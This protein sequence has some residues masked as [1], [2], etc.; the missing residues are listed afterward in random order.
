MNAQNDE[1]RMAN[2]EC[3]S[4]RPRRQSSPHS[5]FVIRH[6][7]FPA[8]SSVIP[9]GFTLFELILAIA[10]WATLLALVGTAI[11]LYLMRVD[12]SRTRVEEAQLA[13]S[14]L[15]MFADDLRS[16]ALYEPQDI[17]AIA[18]LMASSQQADR[19]SGDESDEDSNGN[20]EPQGGTAAAG[21]GSSGA[22]FTAGDSAV[23]AGESGS[24]G[25]SAVDS[26]NETADDGTLPL[27]L[28]GTLTELSIDALR[29]PRRE[30]LFRTITG[31]TNAPMPAAQATATSGATAALAG[32]PPSDV[33]TVRYFLRQGEGIEAGTAAAALLSPEVQRRA[34]GLVRQ[35]LHRPVRVFAERSG[36]AALLDS[37]Q[38]LIAPE[39]VHLEFRYYDGQQV[40]EV[41]DMQNEESLPLAVEVRIWLASP[42][43]PDGSTPYDRAAL[44]RTAHEYRQTVYLPMAAISG[45]SVGRGAG[46]SSSSDG[47]SS[48][49]SN[50]SL[51][52]P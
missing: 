4:R 24:S 49:S 37:G 21:T 9:R 45:A 47:S 48:D 10:L 8:S 36:N 30:E 29:L 2:G 42:E 46:G 26:D 25:G 23:S 18:E 43:A 39:V 3:K 13:R 12:A 7:S 1:A 38:A 17:S 28:T 35:E 33:K 32:P 5:S 6:S 16:A 31:Y 40:T 22:A 34:A 20:D 19:S 52:S 14:I 44:L 27:G 15:A 50:S 41:W 11:N 51:N